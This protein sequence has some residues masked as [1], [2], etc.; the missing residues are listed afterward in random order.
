MSGCETIY[1]E[2]QN[3]KL[4]LNNCAAI[5]ESEK[6]VDNNLIDQTETIKNTLQGR[7]ECLKVNINSEPIS[8]KKVW[9]KYKELY[10]IL[11]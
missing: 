4:Q 6:N 3:L 8:S 5:L 11:K 9:E 10:I 1:T 2:C 7:I